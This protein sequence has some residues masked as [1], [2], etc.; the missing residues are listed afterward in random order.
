MNFNFLDREKGWGEQN[1]GDLTA[2]FMYFSSRA[3]L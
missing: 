2:A 1:K 3:S